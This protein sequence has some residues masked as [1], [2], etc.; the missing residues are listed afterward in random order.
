MNRMMML[1]AS[2]AF[3]L[4]GAA[5]TTAGAAE[6]KWSGESTTY[7]DHFA[8]E[9]VAGVEGRY[10]GSFRRVGTSK[11]ADG[12]E[13][14]VT[15]IGTFET[16]TK[17]SSFRATVV[18]AFADRSTL[19]TEIDGTTDVDARTSSGNWHIVSGTGKYNGITG[20]GTHHGS[21]TTPSEAVKAFPSPSAA[22]QRVTSSS[23]FTYSNKQGEICVNRWEG[24][25]VLPN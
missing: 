18:E 22:L 3:L 23:S 6:V 7:L 12:T 19:V 24:T 14:K 9:P 4:F 17:K 11:R 13:A 20:K 25:A 21:M 1:V 2:A 10:V 15:M 5:I 8:L 16:T